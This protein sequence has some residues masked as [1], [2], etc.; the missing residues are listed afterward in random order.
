MMRW[1]KFATA[2][3]L[4][5]FSGVLALA[6]DQD[7]EQIPPPPLQDSQMLEIS[8]S[9][10]HMTS[11]GYA[12][13][14]GWNIGIAAD[15]MGVYDSNP[16]FLA[17]PSGDEAQRYSG[18]AFLTYLSKRTVYQADY[19]PSFTYY[20]Q[21]SELNSTEQ[22]LSQTLWHDASAQTGYGWRFDAKKY[23]SW[24]GSTFAS[25]SFGS[26][27][28]QLSGLTG[29][30]L[31]SKVS[32]ASTGFTL[33]HR[34]NHHSHVRADF[35]GGVTKYAHSNTDEFLSLLTATDSSTWS[36]L[37]SL[38][39]DYQ[40]NTHRSLGVG[41]SGGYLLFTAENYHL[42]TQTVGF[43]YSE[44]LPH[45]WSYSVSVGPEFREQQ[46][47]SGTIQPG[48]N[49]N[50]DMGRKTRKSAFRAGAVSSYQMG[51]AQ[52]NVTSWVALVSLEHSI[53]R[54]YFAGVLGNYQR[55]E[56]LVASGQLG[57]GSTQTVTPAVDGGIRLDR[58]VM[59][60]ANYGFSAQNGVLTQRETIYRQ[61]FISGLSFNV[62]SLFPR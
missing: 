42:I 58:H 24:G 23:P 59:W 3:I 48:L 30:N 10:P 52:G 7:M 33:D 25:S 28:M 38:V 18:N 32:A 41:V 39:Y 15:A 54:R 43:R 50:F 44:T 6:Q 14:A 34:L 4:S 13:P 35:S 9:V 51:Q 8:P 46:R 62:D 11:Y 27:L 40:L 37:M 29:L 53:G 19:M 31:V 55:S 22:N 12:I 26:L 49:L 60:F 45:S 1:S 5:L 61:Q 20:R 2:A 16:L 47:A 17:Q 56:S 36:G 21:Y 57:T